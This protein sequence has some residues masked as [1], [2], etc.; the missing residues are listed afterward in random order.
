MQCKLIDCCRTRW[1]QRV[2]AFEVF[3]QLYPSVVDTLLRISENE[4]S[5]WNHDTTSDASCYLSAISEFKFIFTLNLVSSVL[6]YARPLTLELQKRDID[7]A[8][9]FQMVQLLR[10]TLND[11]R[12]NIDRHHNIW[13]MEACN[14]GRSVGTIANK[15]RISSTQSYRDNH[16]SEDVSEYYRRSIT[17]QFIESVQVAMSDRFSE[18]HLAV[19]SGFNILPSVMFRNRNW[20]DDM[21]PFFD[22]YEIVFVEYGRINAELHMWQMFWEKKQTNNEYYEIN[23]LLKITNKKMFPGIYKCL[24]ILVTIPVSFS[25]CER[26]ISVLR[27]LKTYQRNTMGQKRFSSLEML[28]IHRNF[29][30]NIDQIVKK[31]AL[32]QPRKMKLLNI[33][34]SEDQ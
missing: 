10:T 22:L 11:I 16:P 3:L 29:E 26:T 17:I 34:D 23:Q 31:F 9:A 4:G 28:T 32:D 19:Y 6:Q 27:R 21:K 7:I 15:P 13:Y 5:H 18:K 30:H 2:D 12:N 33:L 24:K 14:R 25:E 8:S 1:V 20:K